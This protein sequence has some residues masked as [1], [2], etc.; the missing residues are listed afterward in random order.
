M[1]KSW[2]TCSLCGREADCTDVMFGKLTTGGD[3]LIVIT[4]MNAAMATDPVTLCACDNCAR[5]RGKTPKSWIVLIVST[6]AMIGGLALAIPAM[7]RPG[8]TL[9]AAGA[10]GLA[11][12]CIAWLTMLISGCVLST[13]A[14]SS[15]AGASGRAVL[16]MFPVLGLLVLLP[17]MR[18]INETS[19][20]TT[21]LKPEAERLI[22]ANKARDE[23][24]AARMERGEIVS[25]EEKAEFEQRQHDQKIAQ[26]QAEDMKA[27]QEE[28]ARKGNVI[29]GVLGLIVTLIIMFRGI[30]LYSSGTGYFQLF[31][32][33]DLSAGGFAAFIVV[34]LI[35]D[36]GYLIRAAKNR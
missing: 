17:S 35:L 36:I 16:Q 20:A 1:S 19:R 25:A 2:Q 3:K 5:D 29:Y 33:I 15:P 21:A 4:Q 11:I 7:S 8:R 9:A 32:S 14:A 10:L 12:T 28:R 31:G 18:R 6:L 34:L 13:K 26:A 27:T 22:A 30:S 23:E 24:L